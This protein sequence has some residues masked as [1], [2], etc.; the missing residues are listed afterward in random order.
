[1]LVAISAL[2]TVQG[3]RKRERLKLGRLAREEEQVQAAHVNPRAMLALNIQWHTKN[4]TSTHFTTSTLRYMK[5]YES[6]IGMKTATHKAAK[7]ARAIRHLAPFIT[8]V[9][10]GR[11]L[12]RGIN[13][14]A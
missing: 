13:Y 6:R 8:V 4:F 11:A 9:W 3:D 7:E 10:R 5:L 1:M 12:Q 14:E 2:Q